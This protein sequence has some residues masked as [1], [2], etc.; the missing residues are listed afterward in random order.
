MQPKTPTRYRGIAYLFCLTIAVSL[1]GCLNGSSSDQTPA[2]TTAGLAF[3][4]AAAASPNLNVLMDGKTLNTST[5]QYSAFSGYVS[6]DPGS[7]TLRFSSAGDGTAKLDTTVTLGVKAYSLFLYNQGVKMKSLLTADDSP[8][9][10]STTAMMVRVINLSPDLGEV[11]VVLT[12]ES[13]T[14]AEQVDFTEVTTF[15]E[16]TAKTSTV[17]IRSLTD[18]HL[19]LSQTFDALPQQYFT[20][21]IMGYVTPPAGNANKLLIKA[22]V[23]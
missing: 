3:L 18:N 12:G 2:P 9:F 19:I 21:A 15:T 14:L 10:T 23:N 17:E 13:K 4:H 20:I 5:F 8:G 11:R 22:V 7:H 1:S 16:Y 6:V